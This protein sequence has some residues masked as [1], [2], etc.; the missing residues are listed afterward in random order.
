[1][2]LKRIVNH[3]LYMTIISLVVLNLALLF[4]TR[5]YGPIMEIVNQR[6][7]NAINDYIE[8]HREER[9]DGS[10]TFYG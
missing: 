9:P 8:T 2:N 1:M 5:I 10:S 4:G 6:K 7:I 3:K